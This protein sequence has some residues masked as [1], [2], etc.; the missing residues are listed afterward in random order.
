MD[1]ERIWKSLLGVALAGFLGGCG[2]IE[3]TPESQTQ[4]ED[5]PVF[6]DDLTAGREAA[7]TGFDEDVYGIGADWYNYDVTTHAVTP[8]PVVYLLSSGE[9]LQAFE[10]TNYYNEEGKSGYFSLRS[11]FD[12]GDGW[13]QIR[14]FSLDKNV[15]EA[16]VCATT[17]PLEQ[18]DCDGSE[19][20]VF[21]TSM[22]PLIEAGFAVANPAVFTTA[23]FRSD[24][25]AQVAIVDAETLEE[26]DAWPE[27]PRLARS[28]ATHPHLS[29]VGWIV[30]PGL[31]DTPGLV[32]LQVNAD[33]ELVAWRIA[34]AETGET[35]KITIETECSDALEPSLS[36]EISTVN[37]SLSG[38]YE[39]ALVSLC[40][41]TPG[42]HSAHELPLTALWPASS[43]FD[44]MVERVGDDRVAVRLAPGNLLW[45][46][47]ESTEG[48]KDLSAIDFALLIEKSE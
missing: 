43:E 23:H 28:V 42:M 29:R 10:I 9:T 41:D 36:G 8:K 6:S 35:T 4:P 44:L 14:E 15:K 25:A 18:S 19:V 33:L 31:E 39:K 32:H 12:R 17:A 5:E 22:R 47:G 45:N 1:A 40:G 27:E 37:V 11:R 7:E 38:E 16:T 13:S 30:H 48:R 26:V 21:R 2:D 46:W 24:D 34:K 3:T 20:L